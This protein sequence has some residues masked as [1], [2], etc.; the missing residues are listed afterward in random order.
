MRHGWDGRDQ[1]RL[2]RVENFGS[3]LWFLP[4]QSGSILV[5]RQARNRGPPKPEPSL[6]R[7]ARG[8]RRVDFTPCRPTQ[9]A[10][11]APS[12]WCPLATPITDIMPVLPILLTLYLSVALLLCSL[13]LSTRFLLTQ[14]TRPPVWPTTHT[15]PRHARLW[16]TSCCHQ[17]SPGYSTQTVT[18]PPRPHHRSTTHTSD[19]SRSLSQS[20]HVF[21]QS[22]ANRRGTF[23][24]PPPIVFAPLLLLLHFLSSGRFV[25]LCSTSLVRRLRRNSLRH[26]STRILSC[27]GRPFSLPS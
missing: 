26:S 1:Q 5:G 6:V 22:S 9:L 4:T 13:C 21:D 19:S 20:V 14:S 15:A 16:P 11:P 3:C 8:G 25:S 24:R 2:G 27:H 12:S 10:A 7:F 23:S 17:C 18:P